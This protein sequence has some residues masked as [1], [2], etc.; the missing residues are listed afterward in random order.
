M[1]SQILDGSPVI[2]ANG[3]KRRQFSVEG[4]EAVSVKQLEIVLD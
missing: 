2:K 1:Q 4:A 3:D